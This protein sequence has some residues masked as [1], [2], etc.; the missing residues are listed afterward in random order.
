[1][2]EG[3]INLDLGIT[4]YGVYLIYLLQKFQ[5]IG[6]YTGVILVQLT[7]KNMESVPIFPK[8]FFFFHPQ[9]KNRSIAL[10]R[11][12]EGTVCRYGEKKTIPLWYED[13][14]GN[15]YSWHI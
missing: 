10:W 11:R 4:I 13:G 7:P 5:N 6:W 1:M 8:R 15:L 12:M 14:C 9:K 2:A 3:R